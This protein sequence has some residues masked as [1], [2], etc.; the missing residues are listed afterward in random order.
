MEPP[1]PN[2]GISLQTTNLIKEVEKSARS[3]NEIDSTASW[4]VISLFAL[5][6]VGAVSL[7]IRTYNYIESKNV[8]GFSNRYLDIF[9]TVCAVFWVINTVRLFLFRNTALSS[10]HGK[11]IRLLKHSTTENLTEKELKL[12]GETFQ[13]H[14]SRI[15]ELEIDG[16]AFTREW[17][18]QTSDD[19]SRKFIQLCHHLK[20]HYRVKEL[21][22]KNVGELSSFVDQ[23]KGSQIK[24]FTLSNPSIQIRELAQLSLW[25]HLLELKLLNC[26][27][28]GNQTLNFAE[29]LDKSPLEYLEL[30][31]LE[32]NT[33][34]TLPKN[35]QT[36][37]INSSN[38]SGHK[39]KT[40]L[41]D[42]NVKH[43]RFTNCGG[44]FSLIQVLELPNILSVHFENE[45]NYLNKTPYNMLKDHLSTHF[46]PSEVALAQDSIKGTWT[47]KRKK[48]KTETIDVKGKSD[49]KDLKQKKGKQD[50]KAI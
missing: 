37:A 36:L 30:S 34:I 10:L 12:I 8:Q 13:K 15:E 32:D 40:L 38:L 39:I 45:L 20:P 5:P 27:S 7:G 2:E 23:F 47:K 22:L 26:N 35:I 24:V 25:P 48:P 18:T 1:K 3:V 21:T 9:T 42:T 28:F 43:L 31:G 50:K 33:Q 17:G 16:K 19:Q 4:W 44:L 49:S 46:R 11:I 29:I 6:I 14:M 41:T